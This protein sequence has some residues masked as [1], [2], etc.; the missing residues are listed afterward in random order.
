[1]GTGVQESSTQPSLG[2]KVLNNA[3]GKLRNKIEGNLKFSSY[4]VCV[5]VL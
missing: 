5:C 4:C 3:V 2:K 1:M